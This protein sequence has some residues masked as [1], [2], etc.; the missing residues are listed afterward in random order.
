MS[1]IRKNLN[2]KD[3]PDEH[4]KILFNPKTMINADQYNKL[5]KK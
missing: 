4:E 2:K 3:F 1:K 5:N